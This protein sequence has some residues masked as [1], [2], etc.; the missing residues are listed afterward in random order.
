VKAIVAAAHARDLLVITH[1]HSRAAARTAIEADTDGLAHMFADAPPTDE[2]IDL[3]VERDVFV[4][5]TLPVMEHK[6]DD[7]PP[8]S[9][10]AEAGRRDPRRLGRTQPRH[11]VWGQPAPRART[12]DRVRSVGHGCAG[13][14]H[15]SSGQPLR[16]ASDLSGLTTREPR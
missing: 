10:I 15:R 4:I 2:L 6:G 5:G 3:A 16:P 11:G 14:C 1:V 9:T 13:G 8:E 7:A 12:V